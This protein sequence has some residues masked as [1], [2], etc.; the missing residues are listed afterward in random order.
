M[1]KRAFGA[2]KKGVVLVNVGEWCS[3]LINGRYEVDH[4]ARTGH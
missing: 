1:D 4:S 2:M 3:R